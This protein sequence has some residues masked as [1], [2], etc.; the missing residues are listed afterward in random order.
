MTNIKYRKVFK[1]M[2]TFPHSGDRDDKWI[3]KL[4]KDD[5][6]F[7]ESVCGVK[8]MHD[9]TG[10]PHL[11]FWVHLKHSISKKQ[12]LAKIKALEPEDYHR[13]KIE[14]M[15]STPQA[16]F[17][18]YGAKEGIPWIK[19][20]KEKYNDFVRRTNWSFWKQLVD[21]NI[22]DEYTN[23]CVGDCSKSRGCC[24]KMCVPCP[25]PGDS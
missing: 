25:I 10:K 14:G 3:F 9:V 1:W 8:E 6:Y 22:I 18:T 20:Y 17:D 7:Y 15:K 2:F 11:H 12:L 21:N 19:H 4:W 5:I 13:I 16:M 24:N 23:Q